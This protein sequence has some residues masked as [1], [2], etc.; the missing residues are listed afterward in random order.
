MQRSVHE[1]NHVLP[2]VW[3]LNHLMFHIIQQ[4]VKGSFSS[5][6]ALLAIRVSN[7]LK[8]VV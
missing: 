4:L 8:H 7:K 3:F 6:L 5:P 1:I 2:S